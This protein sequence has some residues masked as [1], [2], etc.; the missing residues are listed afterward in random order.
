[1]GLIP[2]EFDSA[3]DDNGHGTHTTS[4]AGWQQWRGGS[5][6]GIR[7][8]SSPHGA[9]AHVVMYRACADAGCYTS[10]LVGAIEQATV[11]GVDAINYSIGGA[12]A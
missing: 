2:D 12:P 5:I 10:D 7:A 1:M 11:D 3:R 8:A 6:Y 4:P 9:R